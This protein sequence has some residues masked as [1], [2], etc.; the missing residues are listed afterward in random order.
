MSRVMQSLESGWQIVCSRHLRQLD[1]TAQHVALLVA[2][3]VVLPNAVMKPGSLP[4][5]AR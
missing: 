2:I 4:T 5:P 1:E 3:A